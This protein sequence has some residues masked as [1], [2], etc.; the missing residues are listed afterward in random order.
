MNSAVSIEKAFKSITNGDI[1]SSKRIIREEYPFIPFQPDK[2]SYTMT[3]KM[4]IFIRDGF[5]DRI[6]VSTHRTIARQIHFFLVSGEPKRTGVNT[7][8]S[9]R[10]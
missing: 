3:E 4:K 2:R 6:C 8:K 9:V 7:A 1:E 5:I 10:C